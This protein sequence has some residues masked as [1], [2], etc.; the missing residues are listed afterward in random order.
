M[1]WQAE[2]ER[3][4][5]RIPHPQQQIIKMTTATMTDLQK[6]TLCTAAPEEE[7]VEED[8]EARKWW[9][10][11]NKKHLSWTVGSG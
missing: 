6:G 5:G 2:C 7:D 1:A 9:G 8:I 10:N 11:K 4:E 3:K